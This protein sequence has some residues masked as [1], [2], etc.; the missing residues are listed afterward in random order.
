MRTGEKM[1]R[2]TIIVLLQAAIFST[3]DEKPVL[4]FP[5]LIS[6]GNASK[7]TVGG[8]PLNMWKAQ[9]VSPHINPSPTVSG[10]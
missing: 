5:K 2:S 4:S 6:D 10:G 1:W 8:I 9:R 3:D 7:D